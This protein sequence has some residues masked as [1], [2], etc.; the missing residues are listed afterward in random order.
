MSQKSLILSL[1]VLL[2]W[3]TLLSA[4]PALQSKD[5]TINNIRA[6]S[7]NIVVSIFNDEKSFNNG[8]ANQALA[9]AIIP[10]QQSSVRI[11]FHQL[12]KKPLAVVVFH[13][14]NNNMAFD[15]KGELPTEGYGTS[16]IDDRFAMPTFKKAVQSDDEINIQ[17]F[18]LN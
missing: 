2:P 4:E 5:I 15:Y 13:D 1:C 9:S 16:N 17:M 10:A 3:S 6:G 8:A 11:T 12:T 7:G 18:Y 14:A